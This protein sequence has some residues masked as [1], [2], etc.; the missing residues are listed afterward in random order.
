[1]LIDPTGMIR[2]LQE[3]PAIPAN[4]SGSEAKDQDNDSAFAAALLAVVAPPR[5]NRAVPNGGPADRTSVETSSETGTQI[6]SVAGGET[7]CVTV[8]PALDPAQ[9]A[10]TQITEGNSQT[11][12]PVSTSADVSAAD[13]QA[14]VD[15]TE[16]DKT[17]LLSAFEKDGK[18]AGASPLSSAPSKDKNAAQQLIAP[19]T[20]DANPELFTS[21]GEAGHSSLHGLN[22]GEVSHP[23][24]REQNGGAGQNSV[25]GRIDE[26]FEMPGN[27]T[28]S[29]HTGN[30]QKSFNHDPRAL[31]ALPEEKNR[32]TGDTAL[33]G[34]F[35]LESSVARHETQSRI[36]AEPAAWRPTVDRLADD[37]VSHIRVGARDAII[38]LDPPELG[39]I[40]ID[41]RMDGDK[42]LAHIAADSPEAQSLLRNHLPE[43]HRA[44][45][46]QQV[47]L[48]EV[49]VAN[50][51]GSGA[52]GDFAQN[53]Q[54]AP[55]QRQPRG[56]LGGG[57][58]GEHS[59][60]NEPSRAQR[61]SNG[62]GRV[63]VWA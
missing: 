34:G 19:A 48:A 37:I 31:Q 49:R 26:T 54:Q 28:A 15:T 52:A 42:L 45:Q 33:P 29:G 57:A 1:M 50:G 14:L 2:A 16:A 17:L 5:V 4:T 6:S 32:P 27:N 8:Q 47:N 46:L 39:K 18:T 44:L 10:S 51:G 56:W 36:E 38:Q 23:S 3:S 40:K 11:G 20:S 21:A 12:A 25:H 55:G 58:Q 22:D 43:L 62:N 7:P 59:G 30:E 53:F 63:S 41:L 24:K 13:P 61:F 35:T 9:I 60:A